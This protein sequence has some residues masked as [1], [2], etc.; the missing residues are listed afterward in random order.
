M[1]IGPGRFDS[2]RTRRAGCPGSDHGLVR[3]RHEGS[4]KVPRCP[5]SSR[6]ANG[7]APS[8][9]ADKPNDPRG[10]RIVNLLDKLIDWDGHDIGLI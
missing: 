3:I 9:V 4:S 7:P 6:S 1:A 5:T 2:S 10:V 8:P